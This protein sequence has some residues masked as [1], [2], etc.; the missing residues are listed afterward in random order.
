MNSQYIDSIS[1]HPWNI[2]RDQKPPTAGRKIHT[3]LLWTVK[4]TAAYI[5]LT[6]MCILYS[7]E[8]AKMGHSILVSVSPNIKKGLDNAPRTCYINYVVCC[9]NDTEIKKRVLPHWHMDR[10]VL[11]YSY[12]KELRRVFE[13]LVLKEYRERVRSPLLVLAGP[14]RFSCSRVK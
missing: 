5:K 11:A 9:R 2:Y 10:Y 8:E 7:S 14:W 1:K 12:N 6:S 13:G 3:K 4:P